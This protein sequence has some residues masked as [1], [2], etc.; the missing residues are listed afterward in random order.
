VVI[1]VASEAADTW[2]VAVAS[3]DADT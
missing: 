3:E 2:V 1:A